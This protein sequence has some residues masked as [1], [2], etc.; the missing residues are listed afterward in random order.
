MIRRDHAGVGLAGGAAPDEPMLG[1]PVAL[2]ARVG[3]GVPVAL[4]IGEAGDLTGQEIIQR[5]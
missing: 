5:L 4:A 3:E 2:H 1:A